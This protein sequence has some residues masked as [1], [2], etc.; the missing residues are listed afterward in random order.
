[1][2]ASP[3]V[4]GTGTA[5]GIGY[6]PTQF[7][8]TTTNWV[9]VQETL[10][11][12]VTFGTG[13]SF[14]FQVE[15]NIP[16]FENAFSYFSVTSSPLPGTYAPGRA[17]SQDDR[18]LAREAAERIRD[19]QERRRAERQALFNRAEEL[20]LRWLSD[21]QRRDYRDHRWFDV[22]GSDGR[23]WRIECAGQSG[24]VQ[25]LGGDGEWV[26]KMCAHPPRG[27]PD[28]DAWLGQA[29]AI[30]HDAASFAAV[31]NVHEARGEQEPLAA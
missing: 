3:V 1:V 8:S 16:L 10:S 18:E 27:L 25:V 2:P 6:A 19:A 22:A 15:M 4:F 17:L 9:G 29:L 20:L 30:T 24:N 21:G 13:D 31:A 14:C 26:L 12:P 28:P 11:T 5:G 7:T 23:R